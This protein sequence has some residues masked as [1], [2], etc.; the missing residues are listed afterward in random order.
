MNTTIATHADTHVNSY[1]M[2]IAQAHQAQLLVV[3]GILDIPVWG[4]QS[5][6]SF[7]GSLE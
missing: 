6:R 5:T 4:G 7:Q 2:D 3:K 1:S